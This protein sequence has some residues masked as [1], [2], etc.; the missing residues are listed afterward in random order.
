MDESGNY[1]IKWGNIPSERY[2]LWFVGGE[3]QFLVICICIDVGM[4][5][6][7]SYVTSNGT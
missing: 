4:R 5:A 2:T 1:C 7:I 3:F 6:V